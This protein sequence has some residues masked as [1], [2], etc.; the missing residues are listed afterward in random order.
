AVGDG[1]GRERVPV[2]PLARQRDE[3]AACPEF[4]RVELDGGGH[5]LAAVG[6]V[7]PA[8]GDLGDLGQAHLDHRFTSSVL[9]MA[10]SSSS[11]SEKG[12]TTPPTSWPLSCPLP[13]TR[14]TSPGPASATA[15]AMAALR[16]PISRISPASA[17]LT[18][19]APCSMAA[20]MAAGSSLRGL[21][22]VTITS[23]L[24]RTAASP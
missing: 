21:S 9:R 23:S 18:A 24:P 15:A 2:D 1:L 16:S 6:A 13:A 19:R 12:C 22:S 10:A 20:L 17:G 3:Q 4:T 5:P 11:R 7:Q 8:A 14:T